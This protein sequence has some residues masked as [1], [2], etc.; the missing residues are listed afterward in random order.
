[1]KSLDVACI[2]FKTSLGLYRCTLSNRC[3]SNLTNPWMYYCKSQFKFREFGVE[4]VFNI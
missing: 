3:Y 4:P 2:D 1:M